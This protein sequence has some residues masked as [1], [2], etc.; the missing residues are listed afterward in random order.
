MTLA[1]LSIV[2]FFISIFFS[3]IYEG[4]LRKISI[5]GKVRE[6]FSKI[7]LYVSFLSLIFFQMYIIDLYAEEEGARYWSILPLIGGCGTSVFFRLRRS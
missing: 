1:A 6:D 5:K 4:L 3:L 2:L 7:F